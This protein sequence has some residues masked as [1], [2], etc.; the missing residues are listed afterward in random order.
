MRRGQFVEVLGFS[1][2]RGSLQTLMT[3]KRLQF[4]PQPTERASETSTAQLTANLDKFNPRP[5]SWE[6]GVQML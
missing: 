6:E 3:H 5:A 2:I 1:H 4:L